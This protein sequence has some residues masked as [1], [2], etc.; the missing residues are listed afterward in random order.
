MFIGKSKLSAF[1]KTTLKRAL[2]AYKR[3]RKDTR[4]RIFTFSS[5]IVTVTIFTYVS[6]FGLILDM[7]MKI[8]NNKKNR[9]NRQKRLT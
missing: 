8:S 6:F 7:V 2:I 9:L 3:G 5:P 4:M 1:M